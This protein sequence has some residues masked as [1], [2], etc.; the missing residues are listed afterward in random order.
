M[1]S[2]DVHST[3]TY[4]HTFTD[5][6]T[7]TTHGFPRWRSRESTRQCRRPRRRGFDP[8]VGKIPWRRKWLPTAVFLPGKSRGQTSLPGHSPWGCNGSDTTERTHARMHARAHTHTH[9]VTC[10][11][12][13]GASAVGKGMVP[14]FTRARAHTHTH[15]HTYMSRAEWGFCRRKRHGS[16][17]HSLTHT[18]THTHTHIYGA[19]QMV[20]VVRTHLPMQETPETWV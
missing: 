14:P 20:L 6:Y 19:S 3:H 5:R 16:P 4:K 10:L 1:N 12:L 13:N 2:L 15:T 17:I 18:H 8:W 7:C 9:R 11:K